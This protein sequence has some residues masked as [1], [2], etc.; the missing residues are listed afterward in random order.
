MSGRTTASSGGWRKNSSPR[1]LQICTVTGRAQPVVG[2]PQDIVSLNAAYL[3]GDW[4]MRLLRNRNSPESDY[5]KVFQLPALAVNPS[6]GTRAN[7]LY[8]VYADKGQVTGDRSDVFFVHSTDGGVNWSQ[9]PLRVNLNVDPPDLPTD[10]WMPA[11]AVKPDGNALFIA[12]NDRR[13]DATNNS[14]IDVYGRFAT[15]DSSGT[16]QFADADFRI[17]TESFSPAFPGSLAENRGNGDYDPVWPPGYPTALPD[18]INLHWWYPTW[19][20]EP[21]ADGED[22]WYG[23]NG[24]ETADTWTHD[25][26]E[27]NGVSADLQF[28][29]VVWADSRLDSQGTS[30][31]ARK[32]ADVRFARIHWPNP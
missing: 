15:I 26:G 31:P 18:H 16:V 30:N 25:T 24:N 4:F 2:T 14:L 6:T 32:Q 27:H 28:A 22:W 21:P 20:P 13:G 11:I 10:Q 9:T 5:F 7:D 12:W 19:F 8:V 3:E 17:T 1:K 29:Y 23:P